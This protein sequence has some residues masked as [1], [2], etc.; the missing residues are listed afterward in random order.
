MKKRVRKNAMPVIVIELGKKI[1]EIR[2]SKKMSTM[3]LAFSIGIEAQHLRRYETGKQEM[4]IS[5]LEKIA[6]GLQMSIGELIE[7]EL[8]KKKDDI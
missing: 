2:E 6:N 4:K 5:M 8:I 1:R 7:Y 3:E